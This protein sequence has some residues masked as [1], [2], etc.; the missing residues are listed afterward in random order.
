VRGP[1]VSS[2]Y[3]E[4][5]DATAAAFTADGWFRTGDVGEF[6]PD[7]YLRLVGRASELIITGGYNVYPR[8]VEDAILAHPD[9][10]DAAV[11]GVADD[12]WG[13]RVVAFVVLREGAAHDEPGLGTA[14]GSLDAAMKAHLTERLAPYKHPRSWTVLDSLP[15]NAMGKVL[16]ADLPQG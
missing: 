9:V 15:R 7:G 13:E 10:V 6:D 16:R 5:P 2:G 8:E 3:W 4:R 11:V 12:T 1:N 14:P